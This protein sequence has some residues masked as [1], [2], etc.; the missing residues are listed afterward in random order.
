MIISML[1]AHL[2]GDYILQWDSLAMW[3]SRALSG[4]L[5]H[6]LIVTLVTFLFILPFDHYWWQG[7]LFISICH[8]FIDVIQL[9]LT[10]RPTTGTFPL[11]R[12]SLDQVLHVIVIMGALYAGGF[13]TYGQFW[14]EIISEITSN[15]FMVY[16]LGYT[17]LAMPAWIVLEFTGYGLIMGSPPDFSRATNKYLSSL[18]RWLITTSVLTGQYLLIPVIAAP[19]FMFERQAISDNHETTI[20]VTKLLGSVGF[21]IAIG[22]ALQSLVY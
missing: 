4:V 5:V 1:L 10:K 12:F 19:R 3:K 13:Y 18:E 9:P 17:V 22:L 15:P 7:A 16:L 8:I 20:Y 21:A 11:I 14:P 2:V 6:G